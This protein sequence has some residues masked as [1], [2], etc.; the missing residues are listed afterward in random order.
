MEKGLSLHRY[1]KT[2]TV[3]NI[4]SINI[5]TPCHQSWQQMEV[6]K[7]GR[8]CLHCAKT[9]VDFTVMTNEEI[10]AYLAETKNVCGRFGKDQLSDLNYRLTLK[11]SSSAGKWKRWLIAATLLTMGFLNKANAQPGAKRT[12]GK[13]QTF[14]SLKANK[15]VHSGK[16]L[17]HSQKRAKLSSKLTGAKHDFVDLVIFRSDISAVDNRLNALND[18]IVDVN[19]NAKIPFEGVLGGISVSEVEESPS[20]RVIMFNQYMPWPINNLSRLFK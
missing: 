13:L 5:T 17:K 7:Q 10:F 1:T 11:N 15:G 14:R 9:V 6:K 16:P 20:S 12:M 3:S 19:L 2:G 18:T 4:K 8:Y